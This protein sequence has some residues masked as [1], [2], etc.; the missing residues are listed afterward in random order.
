[1]RLHR[2]AEEI[3]TDIAAQPGAE[4]RHGFGLEHRGALGVP[5]HGLD[6]VSREVVGIRGGF[7]APYALGRGPGRA[8]SDRPRR[9]MSLALPP[10]PL[11]TGCVRWRMPIGV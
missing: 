1:M 10:R 5:H 2:G 4:P 3:C 11:H 9:S 7:P 8:C 6:R